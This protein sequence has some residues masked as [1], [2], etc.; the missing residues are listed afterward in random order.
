MT[1]ASKEVTKEVTKE[2]TAPKTQKKVKCSD[3]ER[4]FMGKNSK[5]AASI[6]RAK[7]HNQK[8]VNSVEELYNQIL[9]DRDNKQAEVE[10]LNQLAMAVKHRMKNNGI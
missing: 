2:S 1:N 3:C 7:A 5:L 8:N 9:K 4:V 10:Q 6:H